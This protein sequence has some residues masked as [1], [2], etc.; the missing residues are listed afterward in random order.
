MHPRRINILV[1]IPA[2]NEEK[3]I[4]NVINE[5]PKEWVQQVVVVNNASTD[6]TELNAKQAGAIVLNEEKKGYG[7]ACL[8]GIEYARQL[9]PNP[10][11]IVFI[12]GDYSDYPQQIPDLILP[13]TEKNFDLV[14]GS[15]V[16][17]KKE[18]GS[19]TP[20]QIFGNAL[21]TLLI[22]FFYQVHFTDLGPFRAISFNK[23]IA[24]NMQDKT[25]GWTIEM[26]IKAAKMKLKCC[27]IPVN[28]R[29]RIGISKVSGTL[30]GSILA[31]Y[32]II[33]TIIKYLFI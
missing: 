31:G 15:R 18:K 5:I 9:I 7:Y 6:N 13:I 28:Y 24:L 1:I 17:G 26:Q 19:L 25:Y 10:D 4:V 11:I 2:Y 12:D 23:L 29:K 21:A 22:R 27:E 32:K 3:A 30:K 8:K 20:Q 33:F 16:L 14:I